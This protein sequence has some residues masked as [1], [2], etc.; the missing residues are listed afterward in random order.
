M[1]QSK[2]KSSGSVVTPNYPYSFPAGIKCHFYIDGLTDKMNLENVQFS[3][4]TFDV[5]AENDKYV[6]HGTVIVSEF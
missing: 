3:F 6:L 5:P 4:Q 2:G 1:I